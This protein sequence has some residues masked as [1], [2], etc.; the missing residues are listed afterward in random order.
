MGSCPPNQASVTALWEAYLASR[1]ETPACTKR[2]YTAWQF[3]DS[4][5]LGDSL[6]ELVLEGVKRATAGSIAE[7]EAAGDHIPFPGELS[8]VTDGKGIARCVIETTRVD[9]VPYDEVTAEFAF[10]EGEGD[11]S[12][13]YWRRVHWDY[14]TRVLAGSGQVPDLKMPI[15][16]ER[17]DVVF[18]PDIADAQHSWDIKAED[19]DTQVGEHGD[20]N[21]RLNSDPVLWRLCGDVEGL[22][23]LDAGC[24][25]GYLSRAMTRETARVVGV[26]F[27]GEMIAIAK[28]RAEEQ[29]LQIEH[30]QANCMELFHAGSSIEPGTFDLAVS[31]YVMMD[32]PDH[33]AAIAG[34]FQALRPGGV[35]VLVLSHPCFPQGETTTVA[36][37]PRSPQVT[38]RWNQN[39]FDAR[40]RIEPAWGRF[41]SAFPCYHRPISEYFRAFRAAGFAVTDCEEPRLEPERFH[42]VQDEDRKRRSQ[43]LPYSIAFRLEK[44]L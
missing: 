15:A 33:E 26:D 42:L 19:W 12:L 27:S 30:H 44:P 31:N 8:I 39:Y 1:N 20:Q 28:R 38:Y 2:T 23:V 4:P 18:S 24:G 9:I 34:L 41:T 3:G 43:L 7:Y 37:D 32:L 21:R 25:T 35:A 17:F 14:Y 36:E 22:R 11:K 10:T 40:A 16:A 13:E 5:E 6:V 29:D